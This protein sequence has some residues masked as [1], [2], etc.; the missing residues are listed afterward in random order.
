MKRAQ[1]WKK[2]IVEFYYKDDKLADPFV[3]DDQV[4]LL[5]A[6]DQKT[7]DELKKLGLKVSQILSAVFAEC[8]L[9]LIDFKTEWGF[10]DGKIILGDEISPDCCRLWDFKT[11][12]KYDKDRFRRDLGGVAEAYQFVWDRLQKIPAEKR[13]V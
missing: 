2:P 11:R 9:E 5:K 4:L 12:E 6:A 1:Q 8:G 10:K 3:S 13:F 7:I